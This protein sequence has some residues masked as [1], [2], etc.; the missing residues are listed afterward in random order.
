MTYILFG[1]GL[2]L[3]FFG[4][5]SLV[6]GAS[7]AALRLRVPPLVV[8][9]TV[10]GFG[11]SMPELL[12]SLQAALRGAGDI[13]LGNVVGS[14]TANILL[15][16]GLSALIGPMA[17]AFA[18]LRRDL[19]WMLAAAL[20]C[21][22]VLLDGAVSRIEGLALLAGIAAYI[23]LALRQVGSAAAPEVATLAPWKATGLMLLGL[24]ALVAGAHFLVDS[25]TQIARAFGISEAVI[26][27]TI[28]A[29]G[30]SLPELATSV[31]AALKGEREIA[32]GNVIG[33]NVFNVLA[34]LGATAAISPFAA[35]PRFLAVDV[36]VMIAVSVLLVAVLWWRGGL[37]R[38]AGIGF[39]ALYALYVAAMGAV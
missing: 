32:L 5:D 11:T 6:R 28:V 4:G 38:G 3:L 33:S 18:G 24:A 30:T 2:I 15:I 29:V 21:V 25:A 23:L 26:G 16:L 13:A 34:I 39:L 37:G 19:G 31:A 7:A 1:F 9:L 36:P 20:V 22:P 8:G 14:N 27:L 12:V 35:G 10:V 17:A